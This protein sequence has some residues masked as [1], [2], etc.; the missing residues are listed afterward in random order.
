MNRSQIETKP[1]RSEQKCSE[2]GLKCGLFLVLFGLSS[3]LLGCY[4]SDPQ[5]TEQSLMDEIVVPPDFNFSLRQANSFL[6]VVQTQNG[7]AYPGVKVQVL[8]NVGEILATGFSD[9]NGESRISFV[10]TSNESEVVVCAPAIGIVQGEVSV[11][12]DSEDH[13]INIR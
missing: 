7:N 6:V 5:P 4:V 13:V 11:V 8:N 1:N 2:T 9:E 10:T 3:L 12:L